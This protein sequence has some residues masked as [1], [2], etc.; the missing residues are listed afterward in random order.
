VQTGNTKKQKLKNQEVKKTM[1]KLYNEI[2]KLFAQMD[3]NEIISIWNE[4]CEAT[5]HYDDRIMDAY[6][7]EDIFYGVDP[8]ELVNRFFYGSDVYNEESGANPNRN[9]FTLNGYGNI[10]S[11]DYIYNEYSDK[12]YYIDTDELTYYIIEKNEDFC[13]DDI[14]ELLDKNLC[15]N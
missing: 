5:Q 9:Y 6:E 2:R 4:Y 12:F 13:N 15:E 8:L 3:D 1:E 10:V 14:R 11:F 7:L